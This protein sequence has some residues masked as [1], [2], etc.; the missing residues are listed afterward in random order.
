MEE[1]AKKVT[2]GILSSG[3][4]KNYL[5]SLSEQQK[6]SFRPSPSSQSQLINLTNSLQAR[7]SQPNLTIHNLPVNHWDVNQAWKDL[8]NPETSPGLSEQFS[9]PIGLKIDGRVIK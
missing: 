3:P 7:D 2:L 4:V 8:D 5:N 6:L 1:I 9:R